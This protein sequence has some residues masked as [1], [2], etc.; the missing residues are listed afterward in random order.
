MHKDYPTYKFMHKDYPATIIFEISKNKKWNGLAAG[1][2]QLN[3]N[4]AWKAW[5]CKYKNNLAN[6]INKTYESGKNN[7][8]QNWKNNRLKGIKVIFQ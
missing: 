4:I 2:F 5:K 7:Y 1:Y 8:F 3:S 6:G